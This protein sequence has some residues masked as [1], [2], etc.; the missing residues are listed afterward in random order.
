MPRHRLP[1]DQKR[2]TV[3]TFRLPKWLL[4]WLSSRGSSIGNEIEK[5][6]LEEYKRD[7]K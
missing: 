5:I 2:E 1:E 6:L 3:P 7:K 4:D